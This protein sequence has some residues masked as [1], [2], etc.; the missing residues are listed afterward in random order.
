VV[1]YSIVIFV[2]PLILAYR[3]EAKW[4]AVH[5]HHNHTAANNEDAASSQNNATHWVVRHYGVI[6]H[7]NTEGMAYANPD[8]DTNPCRYIRLLPLLGM[9]LEECDMSRR[10]VVSVVLGGAIGFERRSAD[11]PAGIRTMAL[12]SLGSCVFTVGSILAFRSSTMGWDASRVTAALPSGIGFLG[13]A[14]IWKGS[15]KD[16][17]GQD[18]HQVHGLTTAASLWLSAAVGVGAGGALYVVTTYSTI[19]VLLVLRYGP[20]IYDMSTSPP[21]EEDEGVPH[22]VGQD[23]TAIEVP[24]PHADNKSLFGQPLEYAVRR[25]RRHAAADA[26]TFHS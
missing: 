12:V 17:D 18:R 3:D 16:T 5:E 24:P 1:S 2:A 19:L 21:H 11:R 8:Y 9:T 26:P 25:R 23:T 13:G 15:I 10:M 20:K 14:L 4:C 7:A 6:E 22:E